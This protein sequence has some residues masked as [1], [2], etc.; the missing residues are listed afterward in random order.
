MTSWAQIFPGLLFYACCWDTLRVDT[1]FDNCHRI[2]CLWRLFFTLLFIRSGLANGIELLP[3]F[4]LCIFPFPQSV[5]F[6]C[7]SHLLICYLLSLFSPVVVLCV[8]NL[9]WSNQPLPSSTPF[10]CFWRHCL[11][12]VFL[13]CFLPH[14]LFFC[15]T[16]SFTPVPV[17]AVMSFSLRER[18]CYRWNVRPLTIKKNPKQIN[19]KGK[20]FWL[21]QM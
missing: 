7:L 21:L 10:L 3:T 12:L 19:I 13:V 1:V 14:S 4:C 15:L 16:A 20:L 6:F 8:S 2:P 17:R 18:L 11:S 5:L 9:L